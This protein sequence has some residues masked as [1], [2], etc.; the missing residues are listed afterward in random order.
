VL[1]HG[2]KCLLGPFCHAAGVFAKV[3]PGAEVPAGASDHD[4]SNLAVGR[5]LRQ[6]VAKRHL[7]GRIKCITAVR[8]IQR[9]DYDCASVIDVD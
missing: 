4:R 7:H 8:P 9:H 2:G 1:A 3:L 5:D 6:R